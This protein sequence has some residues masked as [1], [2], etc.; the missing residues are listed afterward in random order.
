MT[1]PTPSPM[2]TPDIGGLLR[3]TR[4]AVPS[5]SPPPPGD[6]DVVPPPTEALPTGAAPTP[7]RARRRRG[8]APA[9]AGTSI[10]VAR[11]P[12]RHQ[13]L[14]SIALYLPRSLHQQ[15]K[16]EAADRT[17]TAT[18]LILA[19][20][21]ATHGKVGERLDED[22]RVPADGADLFEIPQARRVA[23]PTAQTTIR[24]TDAQ[25]QAITELAATLDTNR[26]QL[27]TA[28]LRLYLTAAS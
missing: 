23:E 10:Q 12:S 5:T 22:R 18:A 2:Q 19:A 7:G 25:L 1:G 17:T 11:G 4:P 27:I 14:R 26:S 8:A 6:V 15:L 28:A 13:Y 20:V 16:T 21:N 9:G 24:V 3:R